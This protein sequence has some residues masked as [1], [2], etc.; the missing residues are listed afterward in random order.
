M[1]SCVNLKHIGKFSKTSIEG[2]EK[3]E[4]LP[5]SFPRYVRKI[6]SRKTFVISKYIKRNVIV[7]KMKRQIV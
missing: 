7:I 2:I 3:Y 5:K 6:A 1:S 4:E